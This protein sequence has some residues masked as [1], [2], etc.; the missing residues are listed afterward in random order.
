MK[1]IQDI[2]TVLDMAQDW[3][4]NWDEVL[5]Y[6]SEENN[7]SEIQKIQFLHNQELDLRRNMET[8]LNSIAM[9]N[10]SVELFDN[11]KLIITYDKLGIQNLVFDIIYELKEMEISC[12]GFL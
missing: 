2:D 9:N 3:D 7:W 5:L 4:S 6:E 11:V 8:V 10:S 12:N 1:N